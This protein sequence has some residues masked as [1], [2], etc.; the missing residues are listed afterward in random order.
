MLA[1]RDEAREA[2]VRIEIDISGERADQVVD[3]L[4]V[5]AGLARLLARR[6]RRSEIPHVVDLEKLRR[7]ADRASTAAARGLKDRVDRIVRSRAWPRK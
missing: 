7:C 5:A 3:E 1:G 2:R 6:A 4:M